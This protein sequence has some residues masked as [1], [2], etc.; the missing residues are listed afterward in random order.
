MAEQFAQW[1]SELFGPEVV[2]VIL[3]ALPISEVRGGIPYGLLVGLPLWKTLL[4][5]IPAPIIIMPV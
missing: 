5:A 3:S 1:L 4:L 2:V